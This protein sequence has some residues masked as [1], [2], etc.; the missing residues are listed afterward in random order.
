MVYSRKHGTGLA[1]SLAAI[2]HD[3]IVRWP[4][5]VLT[6]ATRIKQNNEKEHDG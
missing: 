4:M 6:S 2:V 5:R 3:D 1:F